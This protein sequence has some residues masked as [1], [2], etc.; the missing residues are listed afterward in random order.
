MTDDFA[1]EHKRA[2][3]ADEMPGGPE[4]ARDPDSPTG[5]AG[6][7][8]GETHE[9]GMSDDRRRSVARRPR[10]SAR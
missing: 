7:D 2:T 8:P 6:A 3:Y 4:H 10:A 1:V 9:T 5:L